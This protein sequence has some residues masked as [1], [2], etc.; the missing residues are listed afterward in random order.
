MD[1]NREK[2]KELLKNKVIYNQQGKSVQTFFF[3]NSFLVG[4]VPGCDLRLGG[5]DLPPLLFQVI[6][7]RKTYSIRKLASL[8]GLTLNGLSFDENPLKTSDIV[9]LGGWEFVFE[10]HE[11]APG[12]ILRHDPP[13]GTSKPKKTRTSTTKTPD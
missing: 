6:H 11:L 10:I 5:V 8:S 3:D 4:T 2:N 13:H 12:T 9:R 7:E 1:L